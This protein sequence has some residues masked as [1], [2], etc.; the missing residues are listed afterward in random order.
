MRS[1]PGPDFAAPT[2]PGSIP[3]PAAR[4]S[5]AMPDVTPTAPATPQSPARSVLPTMGRGTLSRQLVLRVAGLVAAVALLL[6]LVSTFAVRQI[7]MNQLD[8]QL[9][10]A[11][12]TQDKG[13]GGSDDNHPRGI[14]VP[15][16]PSGTVVVVRNDYGT[17]IGMVGS[18]E[19]VE[20]GKTQAATL[21]S[22]AADKKQTVDVP[23]LGQFRAQ[24]VERGTETDVVAVPMDAMNRA[25][26][27]L[28]GLEAA[29]SLLSV[30]LSV[31]VARAVV[32]RSLRPLNRLAVTAT[33]VSKLE[34]DRGEVALPMRVPG[35]DADPE[36]EVGRVGHA[37]N[38]MLNNIEGALATRQE[39]ETK[40]RQFVADA[41][42]ELRNPLAAIRG[43]AELTRRGREELPEDA[44]FAMGRIEAES[45]RMSKL[46]EDMLLLARLDND[47]SN[48]SLHPVDV[49]EVV[50]NATSDAQVSW[51]GKQ[52]SVD[53][54]EHPVVARADQQ[55]LHQ[56]VVNLL[57]NA[58]K[59][60][61]D[62]TEVEAGVRVDG[63]WAVVTV[64]D[65]GPGIDPRIKNQVFER[66]ARA[67]VA[68]AHNSEGSTGLGLAIVQAVMD[69]HGGTAS[70]ESAPGR[71]VFTL[72]VP[73]AS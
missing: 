14:S 28:V 44:Q 50:L 10:S 45:E 58:N 7:M 60:T 8:D 61:P 41:S 33:E 19:V 3:D 40:V 51:P 5:V 55:K 6:S 68:R 15:G 18:G 62:G 66:F 37:F 21:L 4:A 36:N 72:R 34:L 17:R 20:L 39:S 64:T 59:H 26:R 46:V 1:T 70:V 38:H 16:L 52:W 67:D 42:H 32:V 65:N 13:P 30:L 43:Y 48:L 22:I 31:L 2:A 25:V 9:S 69:A 24:R 73:L 12:T 49:V 54:P 27:N 57:A 23:E 71:T 63:P 56:V 35:K 29:L 11:L 53:I 47:P